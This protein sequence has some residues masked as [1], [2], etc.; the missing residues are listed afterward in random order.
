[1]SGSLQSRRSVNCVVLGHVP[2][3]SETFPSYNEG[4]STNSMKDN[5]SGVSL[6]VI[7]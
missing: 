1:M 2:T 4:A 3:S 5:N 7:G 6:S